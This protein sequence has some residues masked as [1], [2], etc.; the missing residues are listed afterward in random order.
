MAPAAAV[1]SKREPELPP[2]ELEA[3]VDVLSGT[4][5]EVQ[6]SEQPR[7]PA[8][9]WQPDDEAKVCGQCRREFARVGF[10]FSGQAR[11]KHH[12]RHC[13]YIFC[14]DCTSERA[15]L[16]GK[17]G[18]QRVCECC[19]QRIRESRSLRL[20]EIAL[21]GVAAQPGI[22]GGRW[23]YVQRKAQNIVSEVDSGV[24]EVQINHKYNSDAHDKRSAKT[25]R[26]CFAASADAIFTSGVH[27]VEAAALW[28]HLEMPRS[29]P[30]AE[31]EQERSVQ[32]LQ[33]NGL[34]VCITRVVPGGGLELR[35][36]STLKGQVLEWQMCHDCLDVHCRLAEGTEL[37]RRPESGGELGLILSILDEAG[38]PWDWSGR[39]AAAQGESKQQRSPP[40]PPQQPR[41][42][43]P[44]QQPSPDGPAQEPQGQV[45]PPAPQPQQLPL[46]GR[47][48]HAQWQAE[49]LS[50]LSSINLP[51]HYRMLHQ[52]CR[53]RPALLA[54]T[55]EKLI[56]MKMSKPVQR[57]KLLRAISK[58]RDSG[59]DLNSLAATPCPPRA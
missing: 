21:G 52:H 5:S 57:R 55:E 37:I 38:V 3:P 42:T 41:A 1:Q 40:T 31:L 48:S 27:T 26:V 25:R 32:W 59:A 45:L 22:Q 53:G 47:Q 35:V 58:V 7:S 18:K 4:G 28:D 39:P 24:Q 15:Y 44:A 14:D 50:F 33:P 56:E 13:G 49:L 16:K 30:A 11:W 8:A 9:Y 17:D 10:P 29:S 43:L 34:P 2:P 46:D 36:N 12:C 54:L 51:D 6:E 23:A 20:K 19:F